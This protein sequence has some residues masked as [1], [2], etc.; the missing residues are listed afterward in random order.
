MNYEKAEIEGEVKPSR[1][2]SAAKFCTDQSKDKKET[3]LDRAS[4]S[5]A[6]HVLVAAMIVV[7]AHEKL[8][9]GKS[10]YWYCLS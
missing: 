4:Q 1:Q 5:I 6:A 10:L 7:P 9:H 3:V 2:K 8:F